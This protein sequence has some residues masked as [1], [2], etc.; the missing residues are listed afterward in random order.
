MSGNAYFIYTAI[1]MVL[2]IGVLF[3]AYGKKRKKR[4]EKDAKIPFQDKQ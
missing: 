2:F 4:F 3:W 1:L